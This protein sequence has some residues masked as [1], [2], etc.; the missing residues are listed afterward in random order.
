[1]R[2]PGKVY[3][4]GSSTDGSPIEPCAPFSVVLGTRVLVVPFC[5]GL[6]NAV[7]LLRWL[8]LY[9]DL[10]EDRISSRV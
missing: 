1:M 4:E 3:R 7:D 9:L 5:E 2:A 10:L 8:P 6:R